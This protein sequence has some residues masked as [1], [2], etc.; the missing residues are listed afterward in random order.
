MKIRASVYYK[1]SV[2][3]WGR[4]MQNKIWINTTMFP[5]IFINDSRVPIKICFHRLMKRYDASRIFN[6][7]AAVAPVRWL[8][9]IGSVD[10]AEE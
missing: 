6:V 1:M 9:S 8:G 2:S 7:L 10:E 4:G 5:P 3:W